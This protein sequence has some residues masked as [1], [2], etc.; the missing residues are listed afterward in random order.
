MGTLSNQ[1]IF[2]AIE[3]GRLSITPKPEFTTSGKDAS[4]ESDAVNLT[5]G[6]KLQVVRGW[7]SRFVNFVMNSVGFLRNRHSGRV[8]FDPA[9]EEIASVLAANCDVVMLDDEHPFVLRP[10]DCVLAMTAERITL[11]PD[12][13]PGEPALMGLVEGRSTLGRAFVTVHITAPFVHN[14]TDHQ[15]TLEIT[16]L[17]KWNVVLRKGMNICQMSFVELV[18]DPTVRLSQFHRQSSPCGTAA[19]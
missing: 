15:I 5:L 9:K 19:A 1:G 10:G 17:G 13:K 11:S 14:G 12:V 7:R 4:F 18:G 8:T 6:P 16:N 2:R 3:S